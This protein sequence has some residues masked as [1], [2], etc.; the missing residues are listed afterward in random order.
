ME[1]EMEMEMA[2][3]SKERFSLALISKYGLT[4]YFEVQ[5]SRGLVVTDT[6]D[7]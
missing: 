7:I 2:S 1:M 3:R 5:Y 6:Y 4:R